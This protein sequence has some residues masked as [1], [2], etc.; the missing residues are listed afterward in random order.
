MKSYESMTIKEKIG[1][2]VMIG[3]STL[4]LTEITKKLINEYKC[5]NIILFSRNFL[6]AKQLKKL[7]MQLYNSIYESTNHIPFIA[8]D[9]EGGFVTRLNKDV[10]VCPSPMTTSCTKNENAILNVSEILAE[11]MIKLGINFDLAPCCEINEKFENPYVNVRSYSDNPYKVSEG[12]KQFCNGLSKYGVLSCLKH[13]PGEGRVT[14]DTHIELPCVNIQLDELFKKEL[15]PFINNINAPCIMVSH[16]LFTSLSK[17]PASISKEIMT[18][19]L[20]N[21]L[22]YQGLIVSDCM[23]MKAIQNNYTTPK[24]ALLGLLSGCDI[25]LVTHSQDLQEETFAYLYDAYEKGILTEDIINEKVERILKYK[26]STKKYL[27]KYFLNDNEYQKNI[28]NE[29][30]V[31]EIVDNSLTLVYK[32]EPK[33]TNKVLVITQK[34]KVSSFVE[35]D[36]SDSDLHTFLSKNLNANYTVVE[37]KDNISYENILSYEINNYDE[38]IYF[39]FDE[40]FSDNQLS[41]INKLSK[42]DNVYFISLKGPSLKKIVKKNFLCMYDYNKYSL[43]TIVK[44]LNKE[45]KPLGKL[46]K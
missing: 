31:Q 40:M 43:N 16:T 24:G 8:I 10:Q 4:D 7:N 1:Q 38:I 39:T 35:E 21:K 9:Q 44:Y 12:V 46:N 42:Y 15:I 37:S 32:E 27:Q 28:A 34:I 2:L 18:D 26:E 13:F 3:F 30:L 19:L 22:N 45:I 36:N 33:L 17:Y 29:K 41:D 25:V 14:G 11:D 23:E 6:N 20:R 5:G